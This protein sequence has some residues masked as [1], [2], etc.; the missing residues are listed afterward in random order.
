MESMQPEGTQP[1]GTA[2]MAN[3]NDDFVVY[4]GKIKDCSCGSDWY[5]AVKNGVPTCSVDKQPNKENFKYVISQFNYKLSVT[6][7]GEEWSDE[8]GNKFLYTLVS[9]LLEADAFQTSAKR[10]F[11]WREY[12]NIL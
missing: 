11:V 9:A 12:S 7:E 8:T 5:V 3:N 6:R 1:E 4:L 10:Y 2:S